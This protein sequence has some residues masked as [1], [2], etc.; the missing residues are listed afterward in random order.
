MVSFAL[1]RGLS[2]LLEWILGEESF[3]WLFNLDLLDFLL[4]MGV[5]NDVIPV[6]GV[7]SSILEGF[8]N[9]IE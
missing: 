9:V 8:E 1:V 7:Q 2:N 6:G 3:L 5:G 4:L